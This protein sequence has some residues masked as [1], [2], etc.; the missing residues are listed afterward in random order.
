MAGHYYSFRSTPDAI[1]KG[2]VVIS[3]GDAIVLQRKFLDEWKDRFQVFPLNHS[4]L[5]TCG[6]AGVSSFMISNHFRR[7]L[8]L[9]SFGRLAIQIPT[10]FLPSVMSGYFHR[11]FVT[12]RILLQNE[13]GVCVQVTS[14]CIQMFFGFIAPSVL[15]PLACFTYAD[16]YR[17]YPLPATIRGNWKEVFEIYMKIA[18]KSSQKTGALAL[19]NFL[20]GL[21][22]C[23]WQQNNFLEIHRI[24]AEEYK[25]IEVAM[26]KFVDQTKP[27]TRISRFF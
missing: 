21:S 24:V 23:Y 8:K 9:R 25:G 3:Q 22:L 4:Q 13:C 7:H 18:R 26:E 27:L 12:N 17:T 19:A 6:M 1:P 20:L 10:V 5:F 15:S 16:R 11:E 2:A 14:I